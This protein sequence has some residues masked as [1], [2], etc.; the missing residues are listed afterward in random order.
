MWSKT[1]K[2]KK[3]VDTPATSSDIFIGMKQTGAIDDVFCQRLVKMAEF[4]N[5]LVH[6]YWEIDT[7]TLHEF[8]QGDLHDFKL[9][10]Q[11]VVKYLKQNPL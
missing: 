8:I 6:L 11:K 3:L 7:E 5:G 9:F 1:K 2:F 10:S 4:R